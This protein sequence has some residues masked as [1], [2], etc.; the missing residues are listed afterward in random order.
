MRG[1]REVDAPM[2]SANQPTIALLNALSGAVLR[3]DEFGYRL[4]IQHRAPGRGPCRSIGTSGTPFS[5]HRGEQVEHFDHAFTF[6]CSVK[7]EEDRERAVIFSIMIGWK[8]E[9]WYLRGTTEEEDFD[10]EQTGQILW[11]SPEYRVTSVH[12]AIATLSGLLD[13]VEASAGV[14]P[15]ADLLAKIQPGPGFRT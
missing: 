14:K 13:A 1:L 7:L 4:Y 3:L 8:Q 12:E 2:N 10:R 9:E 15:V 11:Q 6:G 5:L